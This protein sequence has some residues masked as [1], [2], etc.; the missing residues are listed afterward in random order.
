[1][2]NIP[3]VTQA[4]V[5][6]VELLQGVRD[7]ALLLITS[8]QFATAPII[9]CFSQSYKDSA[10]KQENVISIQNLHYLGKGSMQTLGTKLKWAFQ[11]LWV[12]AHKPGRILGNLSQTQQSQHQTSP[13][14]HTRTLHIF[15][16]SLYHTLHPSISKLLKIFMKS[17]RI[18]E[19]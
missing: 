17:C 2:K 1:M 4:V 3:K 14:K 13:K 9:P 6:V 5:D 15:S 19:K 18:P 7:F 8:V 16:F 12:P 10:H 11:L